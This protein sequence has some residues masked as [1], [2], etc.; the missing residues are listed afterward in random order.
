MKFGQ[1]MFYYKEKKLS[2]TSMKNVAWKLVQPLFNFN[3][4][5][6]KKEPEEVNVLIWTTFDSFANTYLI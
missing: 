2:K 5:I 3:K 1:F 4:S 6:V